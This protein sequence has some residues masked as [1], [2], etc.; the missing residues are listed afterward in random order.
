[1]SSTAF[2]SATVGCSVCAQ[3]GSESAYGTS[4]TWDHVQLEFVMRTKAD[5]RRPLQLWGH[6][7]DARH[8]HAVTSAAALIAGRASQP[9]PSSPTTRPKSSKVKKGGHAGVR[10]QHDPQF[11]RAGDEA[12]RDCDGAVPPEKRKQRRRG[13][14]ASHCSHHHRSPGRRRAAIAEWL[15]APLPPQTTA[16]PIATGSRK[17]M[18]VA[19]SRRMSGQSDRRP[20]GTVIAE[21]LF[22]WLVIEH[23]A[24]AQS[25]RRLHRRHR[26]EP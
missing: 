25:G 14:G 16:P 13:G 12:A 1:M 4:R 17:G 2:C 26:D 9:A 5:V 23:D 11:Y 8:Q 24:S 21:V 18:P 7:L 15:A 10:I 19:I 6:A 3:R 20:V 22:G